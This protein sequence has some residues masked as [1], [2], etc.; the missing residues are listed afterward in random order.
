[1]AWRLG[2]RPSRRAARG[3]VLAALLALVALPHALVAW[4]EWSAYDAVTTVFADEDP[5]RIAPG[6]PFR[7]R[8]GLGA[9]AVGPGGGPLAM[10]GIPE[11]LRPAP[12]PPLAAE[13]GWPRGGRLTVLLLGGDAGPG[14]SGIRTDTM[15]VATL[16][17][18]TRRGA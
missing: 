17:A 12:D 3:A 14:R 1:D 7:A 5:A 18:R 16:D 11:R 4:Y 9:A 2:R 10:A 6:L 13:P 8:A 15:V